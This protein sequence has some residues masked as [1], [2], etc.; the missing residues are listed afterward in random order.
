[1]VI[2]KE[3]CIMWARKKLSRLFDSIQHSAFVTYEHNKLAKRKTQLIIYEMIFQFHSLGTMFDP[4]LKY[5]LS[6][7]HKIRYIQA[8]F[9][10]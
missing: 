10:N 9:G 7:G 6:T 4:L 1:M 3:L 2:K 5:N 8:C